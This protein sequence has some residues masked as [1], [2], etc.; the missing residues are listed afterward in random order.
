MRVYSRRRERRSVRQI[1]AYWRIRYRIDYRLLLA[2]ILAMFM[3]DFATTARVRAQDHE[4]HAANHDIYKDW[5]QANGWSS[6]CNGDDPE[7]GKKGDCRPAKAYPDENGQW[8]VLINGRYVPV[9]QHA[10]RDYEPPD[11]N[12]HVCEDPTNGIMCFIRGK[13]KA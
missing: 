6:C 10:I 12:S 5:T 13:P 4:G 8:H 3:I 1:L 9:P 7:T 11:G 2:T